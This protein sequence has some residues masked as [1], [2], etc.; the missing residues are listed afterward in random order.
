MRL[1][2]LRR[3][4]KAL[5]KKGRNNCARKLVPLGNIRG[6]F[7]ERGGGGSKGNRRSRALEEH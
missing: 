5:E 4:K 1:R 6:G 3:Q 2:N 7:P